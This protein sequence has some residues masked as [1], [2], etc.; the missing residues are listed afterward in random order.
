MRKLKWGILATGSIARTFARALKQASN[1]EL[2]AVG[3]RSEQSAEKFAAEHQAPRYYGSYQQLLDDP[4]VDAVYICPPHPMHHEWVIKAAQAKKH[5]LCEKP[6]AMNER[7]TQEMVSAARNAGVML[8]EAFMYRFH[9]QTRK[10]LELIRQGEIGE[11]RVIHGVYGF[12]SPFQ[13]DKRIFNKDLGGGGILDVGCYPVSFTR[14]VVGAVLGRP[15]ADPLD[16]QAYGHIGST[17]VDE[18]TVAVAKFEN[19]IAAQWTTGVT[20]RY[21]NGIRIYGTRGCIHIPHAHHPAY[22]GGETTLTMSRERTVPVQQ[23]TVKAEKPLFTYA[24]EGFAQAVLE[25]KTQVDPP[26][27][28]WDDSLGNMRTMDAWRQRIGLRYAADGE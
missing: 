22:W 16:V 17:G 5:I 27:M 12:P 7:E 24:I 26:G 4:D 21:E 11:I 20:I 25:G 9:P 19:D 8:M 28:T 3:S 13:P 23:L 6:I 2:F 10:V 14:M 1:G 18:W 15:F